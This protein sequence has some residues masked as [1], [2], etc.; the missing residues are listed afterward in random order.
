[1]ATASIHVLIETLFLNYNLRRFQHANTWVQTVACVLPE[2][3]DP[4][5]WMSVEEGQLGQL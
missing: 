5:E 2:E 1:M 4:A 3:H